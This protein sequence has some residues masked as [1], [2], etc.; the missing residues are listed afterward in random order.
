M[1]GASKRRRRPTVHRGVEPRCGM[2]FEDEARASDHTIV[3]RVDEGGRCAL[4]STTHRR[5]FHGTP[6]WLFS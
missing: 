6:A 1:T 4:L 5:S 3:A 2:R